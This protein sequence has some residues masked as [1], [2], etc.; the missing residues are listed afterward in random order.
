MTKSLDIEAT[1]AAA[2]ALLD[3]R[4]ESVRE[5]VK[6]RQRVTDLREQLADAEREDARAY[7]VAQ[8]K[9]WAQDELRKLGIAD[10]EKVT[11]VRKR[12]AAKSSAT[13]TPTAFSE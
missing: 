12:A 6:A 10:P 8:N 3:D 13:S 11:R 9:G 7:Q 4:V 5:L 2:R 1:A